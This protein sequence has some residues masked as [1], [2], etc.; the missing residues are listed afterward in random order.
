MDSVAD[1]GTARRA[2]ARRLLRA[3]VLAVLVAFV[4]TGVLTYLAVR[5]VPFSDVWEALE[6]ADYWWTLP[7][8][9][10]FALAVA[11]RGLR[12]QL[13]FEPATRPPLWAATSS[14]LIGLFFNQLL[15][16]RAGEVARVVALNQRAGT[17]RTE[18]LA[19]VAVE[20]AIDVLS[21]L[22]VLFAF[23]PLFPDVSW[24][25]TAAILAI[26]LA[27]VMAGVVVLLRVYGQSV[28]HH[29][30]RFLMR[31]PYLRKRDPSEISAS[32]MRG[33][34][35]VR[36]LKL[37]LLATL[38]TCCSWF[39][40]SVSYW[41][42]MQA[43]DLDL[44]PLAGLLVLIATSLAL[45]LPALPAAIGIFEAAT[46]LALDAYGVPRAEALSYGLVIHAMNFFPFVLIGAVLLRFHFVAAFRKPVQLGE[47][48]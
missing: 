10:V 5:D 18:S 38:L 48:T 15:P 37:G 16:A 33:L 20:R 11:V 32:A 4:V 21:L 43:F 1:N 19:T 40:F 44:S 30:I 46:V 47:T 29:P 41:L 23:T 14:M 8:L 39:L 34:V 3:R 17:S 22:V 26:V 24:L 31:L 2:G 12:W 28:L 36:S 9:A 27:A 7:A 42:L 13:M 6:Q 25:R 35:A 45:I